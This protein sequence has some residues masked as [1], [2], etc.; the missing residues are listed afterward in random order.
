MATLNRMPVEIIVQ[1]FQE[2]DDIVSVRN[3]RLASPTC[4]VAYQ[5]CSKRIQYDV[6]LNF[7]S[8]NQAQD[9]AAAIIQFPK[10]QDNQ[11]KESYA[12]IVRQHF[13]AYQ[14]GKLS[15]PGTYN[16]QI[17]DSLYALH[18][19]I[20]RFIEDYTAKSLSKIPEIQHRRLPIWSN[21]SHS[22]RSTTTTGIVLTL[23]EQEIRRLTRAFFRYELFCKLF[24][25]RHRNDAVFNQPQNMKVAFTLH[26][27]ANEE[28]ELEVVCQYIERQYRTL[29][30]EMEYDA[31]EVVRDQAEIQE[32]RSVPTVDT[33]SVVA[34]VQPHLPL[35]SS[36]RWGHLLERSPA[37]RRHVVG[38]L[39][40][41]G[42]EFLERLITS[43]VSL[44]R[45]MMCRMYRKI[46][47]N[48]D[49]NNCGGLFRFNILDTAENFLAHTSDPEA[50][51]RLDLRLR[52][53]RRE[54]LYEI[55][56]DNVGQEVWGQFG[57]PFWDMTRLGH[58]NRDPKAI[59]LLNLTEQESFDLKLDR[60]VWNSVELPPPRIAVLVDRH[61][62]FRRV[63]LGLGAMKMDG[64]AL[65]D[66]LTEFK[67]ITMIGN[68]Y[69]FIP[70]YLWRHRSWPASASSESHDA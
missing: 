55:A 14:E 34:Q 70:G 48:N 56:R 52:F 38:V 3:L 62:R 53:F 27:P 30:M 46:I 4:E 40:T 61:D 31:F 20:L 58:F 6:M 66:A 21:V 57:G 11:T 1:I 45:L 24:E 59:K 42:L 35:Y 65:R 9:E 49:F 13:E 47:R 28:E 39:M 69:T 19:R 15:F 10:V 41:F 2:C 29:W 25:Q 50:E 37:A 67:P 68:T 32:M 44:F 12:D 16:E 51:A 22:F 5:L 36:G 8:V 7:L 60:Y 54:S 17:I 63:E 43:H 26:W 33:A 64:S 18:K 23:S